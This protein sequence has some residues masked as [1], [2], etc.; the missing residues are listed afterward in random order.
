MYDATLICDATEYF[1]YVEKNL[2]RSD[3]LLERFLPEYQRKSHL[4]EEE[5]RSFH[6][7]IAMQHFSTQ[8]TIVELFG[9]D[10]LD[11]QSIDMQLEWLLRWRAQCRGAW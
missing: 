6:G 8:A 5:V 4:T 9:P 1:H 11:D 3:Q 10:C 7:L 2:F